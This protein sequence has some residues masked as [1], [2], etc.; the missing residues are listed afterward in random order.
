M[1]VGEFIKDVGG[2]LVAL[3]GLGVAYAN[4]RQP[5]REA[6]HHAR[7]ETL[8]QDMLD[9]L[10]HR[11]NV[12]MEQAGIGEIGSLPV[13]DPNSYQVTRARI[14]LYASGPV[15]ESWDKVHLQLKALELG[16]P[17]GQ[18]KITM[19]HLNATEAMIGELAELMRRDLGVPDAPRWSRA[20]SSIRYGWYVVGG[21]RRRE[22]KALRTNR[23]DGQ[24]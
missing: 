4:S 22:I 19:L 15:T 13:R 10:Q 2:T 20:W 3:A 7:V 11:L 18:L 23:S 17:E 24:G 8:Y 1:G 9:T 14:R 12:L 5:G 16:Q 21:G 6:R